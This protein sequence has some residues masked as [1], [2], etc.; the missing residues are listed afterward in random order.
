MPRRRVR[1]AW[2]GGPGAPVFGIV[3]V[4]LQAH[5]LQG[6]I[7]A[8]RCLWPGR[9]V[10][11][12]HVADGASGGIFEADELAGVVEATGVLSR[13][14][15]VASEVPPECLRARRDHRIRS[16][17]ERQ[18]RGKGE[19]HSPRERPATER[20]ALRTRVDDL[21]ELASRGA[22]ARVV[23]NLGDPNA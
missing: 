7:L 11:V 16:G 4:A 8:V 17:L 18:S 12:A 2:S 15:N 1:V 14:G 13:D 10:G 5:A 9:Q 20:D 6:G 22:R 23:V 21:D 3:H 19:A